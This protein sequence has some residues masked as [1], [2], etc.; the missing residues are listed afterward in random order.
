MS[1][2]EV[3][4]ADIMPRGRSLLRRRGDGWTEEEGEDTVGSP[5]GHS[6]TPAR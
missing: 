3:F 6:S 1:L 4:A 2:E 5:V